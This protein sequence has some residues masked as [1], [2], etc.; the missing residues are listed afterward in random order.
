MKTI[1]TRDLIEK[2]EELQQQILDDFNE[3]FGT[4]FTDFDE[5]ILE[6]LDSD[7]FEEMDKDAIEDFKDYWEPE[8]KAIQEI[9]DVESEVGREFD[10]GCTLILESNFKEYCEE[11][12]S[13]IGDLPKDIP[14]YLYNNIDW[15]GVADDLKADYSELDYDGETYLY[16]A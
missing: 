6:N 15:D 4:E 13:D 16:R 1:D 2:R 14:S 9:D 8:Y 12:V 7:D 5:V 10:Y 11:L 3:K